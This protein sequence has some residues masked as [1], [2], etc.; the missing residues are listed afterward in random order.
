M[1]QIAEGELIF[2]MEAG[3]IQIVGLSPEDTREVM[4]RIGEILNE[5]VVPEEMLETLGEDVN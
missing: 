5:Y 2:D 4:E 3:T 1:K